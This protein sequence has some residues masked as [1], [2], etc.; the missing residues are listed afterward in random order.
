MDK[1]ENER[2]KAPAKRTRAHAGE[3]V[4]HDAGE[5]DVEPARRPAI[6]ETLERA[7]DAMTVRRVYGDPV[8]RDGVIVIPAAKVR[9]G[10]GGG[11]DAQG[12]GGGGFGLSA[13]P[14]GAFVIKDG[15]VRWQAAVDVNR[16]AFW[17][18]MVAIV[19]WLAIRSIARSR[20]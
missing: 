5:P 18:S 8:E 14:A 9:G 12:N 15:D 6:F 4:P 11:G 13:T 2:A 20:R 1:P 3:V 10:G 19:A 7:R 17:G 16:I